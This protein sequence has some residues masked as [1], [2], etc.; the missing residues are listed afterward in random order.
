MSESYVEL[1]VKRETPMKDKILSGFVIACAAVF[2]VLFFLTSNILM[3][4]GV[5]L[6]GV[7]AYF[8]YMNANL[9]YE[10]LY[11]DKE[12]TVDKIMAKSKR[13]KIAQINMER[14]EVF[15]PVNSW[16]VA[17]YKDRLGKVADYSSGRSEANRY[18]LVHNGQSGVILEPNEALVHAIKNIAPRKVF[19][20]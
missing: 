11:V 19:T 18:L 1:L 10:Y 15:A 7:A 17:D 12:L 2:A 5:I 9:E 6:F 20:D 3:L 14:L 16:H 4:L 13:K 8:A